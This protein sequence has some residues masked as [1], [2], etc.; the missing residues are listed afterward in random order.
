VTGWTEM[1]E[2]QNYPAAK[3]HFKRCSEGT[4]NTK[5]R[6]LGAFFQWLEAKAAFL[7]GNQG[8]SS[9]QTEAL[10]LLYRAI[11]RGG[12][13]AWFNR[14]RTSLNRH[15]SAPNYQTITL[16]TE[17]A[18]RVVA[19]FNERLERLGEKGPAFQRWGERTKDMLTSMSHAQYQ[20]GLEEL[21]KIL[22]YSA[23]RPKYGAAT[24]CRW[25]GIF[26]NVRELVTFEAKIE[27]AESG[28]IVPSSRF[29][30]SF[31]SC[32]HLCARREYGIGSKAI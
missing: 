4:S 11:E 8:Y 9:T 6:E 19:I 3:L 29:R 12:Q 31:T 28:K 5:L 27:H 1:F 14:L 17:Y 15:S 21:G 32:D 24:D 26:G 23:V 20:E 2:R 30:K 10:D 16:P 7:S 18:H 13:S 25:R 22:G